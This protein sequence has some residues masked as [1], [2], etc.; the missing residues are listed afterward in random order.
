MEQITPFWAFVLGGA[1]VLFLYALL[2]GKKK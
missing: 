2:G 1:A